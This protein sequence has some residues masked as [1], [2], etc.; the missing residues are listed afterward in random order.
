MTENPYRLARDIHGIGFKSADAI[1]M[2]LGIEKTA[3]IRLRAGIDVLRSR[4]DRG[5]CTNAARKPAQ[6][7]IVRRD[8][9]PRHDQAS[10]GIGVWWLRGR[11]RRPR[12]RCLS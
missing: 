11:G 3:M 6:S 8:A 7:T 12:A 2:K 5:P 10:A 9:D 4:G 1:A